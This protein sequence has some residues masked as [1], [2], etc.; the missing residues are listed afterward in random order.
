MSSTRYSSPPRKSSNSICPLL[1]NVKIHNRLLVTLE[2]QLLAQE[3]RSKSLIFA[4]SPRLT[5]SQLVCLLRYG[6]SLRMLNNL[7]TTP[8]DPDV[9]DSASQYGEPPL[10]MRNRMQNLTLNDLRSEDMSV[11]SRGMQQP[12]KKQNTLKKRRFKEID[13]A[14]DINMDAKEQS[15]IAVQQ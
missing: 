12:G 5:Q 1:R 6:N 11:S 8:T 10:E 3:N 9:S 13:N 2:R 7:R 4:P 14:W 15:L